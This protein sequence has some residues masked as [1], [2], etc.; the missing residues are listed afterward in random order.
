MLWYDCMI[1]GFHCELDANCALLGYYM[2]SGIS[3]LLFWDNL[4][5]PSSRVKRWDW[6]VVLKCQGSRI[7]SLK[8]GT[9]ELSWYVKGQEFIPLD[10]EPISC[11]QNVVMELHCSHNNTEEHSSHP[12]VSSMQSLL[13]IGN[14][15]RGCIICLWVWMVWFSIKVMIQ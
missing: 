11:L 10:L 2:S 5:F 12:V 7:L 15:R 3:W 8:I 14:A 9:G 1:S 6:Y 4:S 13:M